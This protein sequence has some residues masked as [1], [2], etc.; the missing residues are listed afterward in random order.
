MRKIVHVE[1]NGNHE[2]YGCVKEV[3]NHHTKEEIGTTY[4]MFRK[5]GLLDKN[6]PYE[7]KDGSFKIRIGYLVTSERSK[8]QQTSKKK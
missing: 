6:T 7:S 8:K 4:N 3:F 2:Y 1:F 5:G